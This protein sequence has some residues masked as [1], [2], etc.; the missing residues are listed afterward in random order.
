M[1]F[2]RN[3][4]KKVQPITV[5]DVSLVDVIEPVMFDSTTIHSRAMPHHGRSIRERVVALVEAGNYS[6]AGAGREYGV[7]PSTASRWIRQ[8][9]ESGEVTRRPGTGSWRV[10][11]EAEDDRLVAE[12]RARPFMNSVQLRRSVNFPGSTHTVLRRLRDAGLRSRRAAQKQKLTDEQMVYRLAFA[13]ENIHR[14]W[15]DVIFSDECIFSSANDGPIRVF[16]PPGT[17]HNAEYVA[18]A[19]RSGRV[20][21]ACWGWMSARGIGMLHRIDQGPN[22]RGLTGGQ[23]VQILENIM[24]PSVRVLYPDGIIH[25]QQDQSPVHKSQ[26]V[27]EW[28]ARQDQVELRLASCGADL[29]PIENVWAETKRTMSDNWPS[30]QPTNSDQLWELVSDAWDEVA[31][32]EGY[33]A[34][35]VRSLPRRLSRVVENGGFWSSY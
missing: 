9:R 30:S 26:S 34:R 14:D 33:A 10:S 23:Y 25:F 21:V 22:G 11:T 17:R 2:G 1:Y 19:W 31:S 4:R 5:R 8:W 16:R 6:A 35:L 32:S 18:E 29:N 20:S 24:V 12:A 15:G 28:F 13:E 27:Q 7:S 3:T